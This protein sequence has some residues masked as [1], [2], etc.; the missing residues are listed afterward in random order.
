MIQVSRPVG[1]S[2]AQHVRRV[3]RGIWRQ[4]RHGVS[5]GKRIAHQSV[6]QDQRRPRAGAEVAHTGTVKIH[7]AFLKFSANLRAN[8]RADRRADLRTEARAGT[9]CGECRRARAPLLHIIHEN[10]P[11]PEDNSFDPAGFYVS[12]TTPLY[13]TLGSFGSPFFLEPVLVFGSRCWAL[14]PSCFP[15]SR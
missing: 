12:V 2:S 1:K 11:R 6:Q 4:R 7:P 3:D 9:V 13:F 8:L 5:P 15:A 10:S 14:S